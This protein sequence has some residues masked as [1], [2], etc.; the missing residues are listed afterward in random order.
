[1]TLPHSSESL[2]FHS[3]QFSFI[4]THYF[5]LHDPYVFIHCI[6]CHP[7]PLPWSPATLQDNVQK[8]G[9]NHCVFIQKH[10]RF[11]SDSQTSRSSHFWCSLPWA[12]L[13]LVKLQIYEHY[14]SKCQRSASEKS[15]FE[16]C[17][18]QLPSMLWTWSY[19][20]YCTSN[21]WQTIN[22]KHKTQTI[23]I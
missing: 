1:M 13:H 3:T 4:S 23:F 14:F 6:S 2:H 16:N 19:E 20:K 10:A 22:T 21:N 12:C 17:C 11:W 18:L 7:T 9:P 5:P 8:L 15:K